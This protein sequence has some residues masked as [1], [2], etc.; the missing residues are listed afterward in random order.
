MADAAAA[1]AP[2][3]D[4]VF[5]E[6]RTVTRG[7]WTSETLDAYRPLF[8]DLSITVSS[9]DRLGIAAGVDD[10]VAGARLP[11]AAEQ[12][13]GQEHDDADAGDGDAGDR[14]ARQR[15]VA[16]PVQDEEREDRPAGEDERARECGRPASP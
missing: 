14:A 2:E 6:P 12:L 1:E 3:G 5:P 9:G 10:E 7:Q 8:T 13:V 15:L 11:V 4:T 16:V